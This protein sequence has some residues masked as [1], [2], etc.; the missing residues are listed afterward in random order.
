MGPCHSQLVL[1]LMPWLSWWL[2]VGDAVLFRGLGGSW[3][4]AGTA[5]RRTGWLL[6]SVLALGC[7]PVG[8]SAG[9]LTR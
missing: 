7:G 6:E 8:Q 5:L 2:V 3:D 9:W 4:H 1:L